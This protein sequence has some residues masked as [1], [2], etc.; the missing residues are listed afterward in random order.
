MAKDLSAKQ[1]MNV[2]AICDGTVI[3]H[4]LAESTF[5]VADILRVGEEKNMVMVAANL[6]STKH[7]RKGLIKIENRRLTPQEVN[8]IALIAP[9]ATLNI[10]NDYRVVDKFRV[11]L[12]AE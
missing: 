11:E 9:D 4:I 10:I 5:K 12:P 8:K 6:R 7:G 1:K 2:S 3:D